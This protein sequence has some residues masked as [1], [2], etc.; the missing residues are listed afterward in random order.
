MYKS[1]KLSLE[2][3]G[4]CAVESVYFWVLFTLIVWPFEAMLPFKKDHKVTELQKLEHT[5]GVLESAIF[6]FHI[7]K[8]CLLTNLAEKSDSSH[9]PFFSQEGQAGSYLPGQEDKVWLALVMPPM[10]S[11]VS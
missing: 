11:G 4:R 3:G 8:S 5:G 1:L 7:H 6:V 9:F 2:V 10:K